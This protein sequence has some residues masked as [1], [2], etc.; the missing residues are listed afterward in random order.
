MKYHTSKDLV[1]FEKMNLGQGTGKRERKFRMWFTMLICSPVLVLL[2]SYPPFDRFEPAPPQV[3][4]TEEISGSLRKLKVLHLS[5]PINTVIIATTNWYYKIYISL[6]SMKGC[7]N[8]SR[9]RYKSLQKRGLLAPYK[10]KKWVNH[11]YKPLNT[12][13]KLKI[14]ITFCLN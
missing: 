3:L 14:L 13:H 2:K 6:Y 7:C 9:D 8:L 10:I 12:P 4:L 5:L 1:I 11:T